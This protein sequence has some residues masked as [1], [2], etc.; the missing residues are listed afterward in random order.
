MPSTD[1]TTATL[2]STTTND[3][4][5]NDPVI[6][7]DD[8][9]H[10]KAITKYSVETSL[11]II[12]KRENQVIKKSN[13]VTEKK[14][15]PEPENITM[16]FLAVNHIHVRNI[17]KADETKIKDVTKMKMYPGQS[18]GRLPVLKFIKGLEVNGLGRYSPNSDAFKRFNPN[19][20]SCPDRDGI[21]RKWQKLCLE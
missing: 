18:G 10:A 3:G 2:S 6:T 12:K 16:E 13:S 21:K 14:I 15:I 19:E 20:E 1:N 9:I 11:A 8:F 7:E 17:L 5:E 4:I